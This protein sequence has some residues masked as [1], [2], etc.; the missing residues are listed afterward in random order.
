MK[1]WISGSEKSLIAIGKSRF[2]T[3]LTLEVKC[4]F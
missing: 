2:S 1:S 4:F 3:L